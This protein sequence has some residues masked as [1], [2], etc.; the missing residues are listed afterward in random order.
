MKL[1][2]HLHLLIPSSTPSTLLEARLYLP[3][4]ATSSPN[5]QALLST[6][7]N[8]VPQR[9]SDVP[10]PCLGELKALGVKRLVTAAHPWGKLGGNMLDP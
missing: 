10:A 5:L 7:S 9:L 4:A 3:L 6:A 8:S 2:P 1:H